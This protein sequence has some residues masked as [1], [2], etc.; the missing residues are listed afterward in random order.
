VN[1]YSIKEIEAITGIKAHT[2]R[3][4]EQRYGLVEPVRTDTNIRHYS[5]DQ[6]KVLLNVSLLSKNG[7]RISEIAKLS[8]DE[9][10]SEVK[11][12]SINSAE[13]SQRQHA[14]T[15]AMLDLHEAR[16]EKHLVTSI[17]Q[18]GMERT[19]IE[20][21]FPFF[22]SIGI[23][24]QTGTINPAHEHFITNLVRQKLIVAIDG[25]HISDTTKGNF[26]LY[27]PENELHEI[28]LLFSSY[29]LRSRGYKVIYLGQNVPF[30]DLEVVYKKYTRCSFFTV[31]TSPLQEI[32]V[33]QYV[34]LLASRFPLEKIY[35]SGTQVLQYGDV[36]P[37]NVK[38]FKDLQEFLDTTF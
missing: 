3:V 35:I 36:F 7:F 8:T 14:L 25:Q 23:M 37:A 16:F 13:V 26:I 4:W 22:K 15:S 20:V 33:D 32:P 34:D 1:T 28:G 19:M 27:L 18:I 31:I 38:V 11:S 2:L 21:L 6:L 5:E 17:L 12:I 9:L 10:S 29:V 24:W 30:N